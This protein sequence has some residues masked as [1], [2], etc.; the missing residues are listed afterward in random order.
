MPHIGNCH[1]QPPPFA[2]FLGKDSVVKITGISTIYGNQ[3]RLSKVKAAGKR[4]IL[5]PLRNFICTGDNIGR[6]THREAMLANGY[7]SLHSRRHLLSKNLNNMTGGGEPVS[8]LT[9]NPDDHNLTRLCFSPFL[10]GNHNILNQTAII[11]SDKTNPIMFNKTTDYLTVVVLKHFD[12]TSLT[13]T[14]V[15]N[16]A[17]SGQHPV[18]MEYLAHLTRRE[19]KIISLPCSKKA[20]PIGMANNTALNHVEFLGE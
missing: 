14:P 5:N 7:F 9:D 4:L 15:V 19:K 8:R 13:P 17:D 3:G 12:N 2:L 16:P 1:Q 11:R 20:K 10:T 6:P 18:P